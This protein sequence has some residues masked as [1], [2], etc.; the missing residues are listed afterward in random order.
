MTDPTP[1]QEQFFKDILQSTVIAVRCNN[2]GT[3]QIMNTA[4]AKYVTS[5]LSACGNCRSTNR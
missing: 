5:G 3:D 1:D 2:C 4:Y